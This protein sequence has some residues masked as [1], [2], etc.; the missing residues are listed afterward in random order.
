MSFAH[1]MWSSARARRRLRSS[2]SASC[3]QGVLVANAV[4][5]CASTPVIRS[6]APG[7][8]RSLR[9]ITGGVVVCIR[10]GALIGVDESDGL[11]QIGRA[12]RSEYASTLPASS[13][14]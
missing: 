13:S 1:R 9:T 3:P 10:G 14:T 7:C 12:M 11:A 5:R 6:C 8:G 4:N 2:R